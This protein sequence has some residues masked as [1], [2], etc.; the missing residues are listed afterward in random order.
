[1][2]D[3]ML[4]KIEK[5]QEPPPAKT[6]KVLP[7]PD[8][9]AKKRRGGKRYR[10]MKERFGM[11]DLR[12]QANRMMF[13]QAEEEFVDG[14]DTIGLGV[15]GKEGSGR[16]RAVALQQRQKLSAKAQKKVRGMQRVPLGYWLDEHGVAG[17]QQHGWPGCRALWAP[18]CD[19]CCCCTAPP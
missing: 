15:I 8:G 4:K 19:A 11:T 18:V 17:M 6:A 2:K 14:E 9:E 12:K 3:D 13:N 7:V 1:M 5:W 10:K 16:L